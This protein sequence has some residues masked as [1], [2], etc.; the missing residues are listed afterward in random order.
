MFAFLLLV[1]LYGSQL[2]AKKAKRTGHHSFVP[3]VDDTDITQFASMH[4]E[5][6]DDPEGSPFRVYMSQ[7]QADEVCDDSLMEALE[8]EM[9]VRAKLEDELDR[10]DAREALYL[11]QIEEVVRQLEENQDTDDL[12]GI[13]DDL[14]NF[15]QWVLSQLGLIADE[16][17]NEDAA[18]E[19]LQNG[20]L[21]LDDE[22]R[23]ALDGRLCPPRSA[24]SIPSSSSEEAESA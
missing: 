10:L 18:A 24:V 7:S 3:G 20:V 23:D 16:V 21:L 9:E 5:F 22:L 19:Q 4:S 12:Q 14:Y 11:K 13:W 8:R 17:Q 15:V 6:H 1:S 2:Q